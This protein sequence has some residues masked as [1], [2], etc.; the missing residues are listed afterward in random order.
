MYNKYNIFKRYFFRSDPSFFFNSI[1]LPKV[2]YTSIILDSGESDLSHDADALAMKYL[3]D[4]QLSSLAQQRVIKPRHSKQNNSMYGIASNHMSFASR[5]YLER[6]GLAESKEKQPQA[7]KQEIEPMLRDHPAL[8]NVQEYLRKLNDCSLNKSHPSDDIKQTSSEV[9]SYYR[10][11]PNCENNFPRCHSEG[12]SFLSDQHSSDH[13]PPS[14]S[15]DPHRH[16]AH[17]STPT[18][19]P[20]RNPRQSHASPVSVVTMRHAGGGDYTPSQTPILASQ[21]H[22]QLHNTSPPAAERVLDIERLKRLP[23]LL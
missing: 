3:S 19:T 12:E 18:G 6:Y 17:L 16:H 15:S 8:V 1:L 2:D 20:T 11:A 13:S 10:N 4:E 5:K 21:P 23:K 14:I 22:S 7:R 9:Q